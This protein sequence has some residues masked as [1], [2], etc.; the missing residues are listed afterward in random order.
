MRSLDQLKGQGLKRLND[1]LHNVPMQTF[2]CLGFSF[3]KFTHEFTLAGHGKGSLATVH[4]V[5]PKSGGLGSTTLVTCSA[6]QPSVV[7]RR[8]AARCWGVQQQCRRRLHVPRP[9][10]TSPHDARGHDRR[11]SGMLRPRD[12]RAPG[13]SAALWL[14]EQANASPRLCAKSGGCFRTSLVHRTGP[15]PRVQQTA[16]C[17]S[18]EVVIA[19]AFATD[20]SQRP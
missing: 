19:Q 3:V 10:E 13:W 9:G 18:L 16:S 7:P 4:A 15:Y 11:D 14:G 20:H 2:Y 5:V 17:V 8:H 12:C 6:P 1:L